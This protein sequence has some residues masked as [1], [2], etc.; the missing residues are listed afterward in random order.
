MGFAFAPMWEH[1]GGIEHNTLK[2]AL[3][4][5]ISK[6]HNKPWSTLLFRKFL[7]NDQFKKDYHR[8]HF[9]PPCSYSLWNN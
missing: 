2:F 3:N 8:C 6:N 4:D 1:P 7:E 9:I 5:S